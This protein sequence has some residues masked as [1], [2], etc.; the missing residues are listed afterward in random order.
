M[1]IRQMTTSDIG[2]VYEIACG[3][4]DE[5]YV[6]EVFFLFMNAWPS[7]QL[8]AVD[9]F[10]NIVGFLSGSRLT[11]DSVTI[12]LFAVDHR[13]R[14]KGIGGRLLEDFKLRTAMDGRHYIKLEVRDTNS[15]ALSFYEKKGFTRLQYLENF[16]NNGGN[17]IR[18]ICA[19]RGNA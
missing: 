9:V 14:G 6:Q 11:G 12:S 10:G 2:R 15:H 17:A 5:G 7:G 18:M 4:L 3:S 8:V 16:Y 1:I 19:V 13:N